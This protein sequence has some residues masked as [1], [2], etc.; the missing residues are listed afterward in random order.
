[1]MVKSNLFDRPKSDVK[2]V[3]SVKVYG[4]GCVSDPKS[5]AFA[6]PLVFDGKL[7]TYGFNNS[8]VVNI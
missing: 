1:M 8:D 6:L 3:D 5:K 2:V 4:V 7:V